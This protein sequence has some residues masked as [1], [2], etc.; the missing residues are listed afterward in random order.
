M[1][2]T[3]AFLEVTLW[4]GDRKSASKQRDPAERDQGHGDKT[5]CLQIK[6]EA[7][8]T[9]GTAGRGKHLCCGN[10]HD[11]SWMRKKPPVHPPPLHL[12]PA[13][14]HQGGS[15]GRTWRGGRAQIPKA[16]RPQY[17][18]LLDFLLR[19]TRNHRRVFKKGSEPL[20]LLGLPYNRVIFFFFTMN[21][22]LS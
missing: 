5:L 20:G 6:D 22:L 16:Q 10:T 4:R 12:P 15:W 3:P 1:G 11:E 7:G 13:C 19:V 17:V 8:P 2:K 9:W 21:M 18:W 14:G